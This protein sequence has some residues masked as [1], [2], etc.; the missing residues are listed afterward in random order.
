MTKSERARRADPHRHFLTHCAVMPGW[1]K[2]VI[3]LAALL[4]V[5]GLAGTL[6]ARSS[7]PATS[8]PDKQATASAMSLGSI[9]R[10][11]T[12]AMMI[13]ASVLVGFIGGWF[14]R[15]Y[16]L[17]GAGVALLG[18]AG[19]FALSHFGIL[20]LGATGAADA[21]AASG[22]KAAGASGGVGGFTQYAVQL[23]DVA[24]AHL[25]STGSGIVAAF[26]GFRRW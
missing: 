19:V 6:Y 8:A 11:S 14:F 10:L 21:H 7:T 3:L 16:L 20:H 9:I 17:V 4:A 25:P 1:H 2:A 26:L 18:L 24:L 5:A 23:K 15:A 22:G 12:P 13:G